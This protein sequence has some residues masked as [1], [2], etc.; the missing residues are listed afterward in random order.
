[1]ATE[2][3][4][5]RIKVVLDIEDV[6]TDAKE[7]EKSVEKS[8]K[9][10]KQTKRDT[11]ATGKGGTADRAQR[12]GMKTLTHGTLFNALTEVLKAIPVLGF[13]FAAGI[14]VAEGIERFGPGIGAFIQKTVDERLSPTA[15]GALWA[16]GIDFNNLAEMSQ[17]WSETKAILSSFSQG[18]ERATQTSAAIAIT[19][20]SI[21][22]AEA[23][24]EFAFHR[25]MARFEILLLKTRRRILQ[26]RGGEGVA[27][28][29]SEALDSTLINSVGK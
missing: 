1:M 5:A 6:K 27:K 9:T 18:F 13:G 26:M 2:L 28:S 29:L 7:V 22:P 19:G 25:D 4:E 17:G 3:N 8:A 16:A 11:E 14:G 20:G 24:Q 21:S 12:I 10:A 15:R 23:K